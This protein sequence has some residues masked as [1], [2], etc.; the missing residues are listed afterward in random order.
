MAYEFFDLGMSGD[1]IKAILNNAILGNLYQQI[2]DPDQ[3]WLETDVPSVTAVLD[4][5]SLNADNLQAAYEIYLNETTT[6]IIK[7]CIDISKNVHADTTGLY[8]TDTI[9]YGPVDDDATDEIEPQKFIYPTG[10]L[11]VPDVSESTSFTHPK[12]IQLVELS[13]GDKYAIIYDQGDDTNHVIR[14]N[15]L[16]NDPYYDEIIFNINFEILDRNS[17]TDLLNLENGRIY[18]AQDN[19]NIQINGGMDPL[20]ALVSTLE[21]CMI[22]TGNDNEIGDYL[23]VTGRCVVRYEYGGEAI[24]NEYDHVTIK[25]TTTPGEQN[26]YVVTITGV[27]DT[28]KCIKYPNGDDTVINIG[29]NSTNINTELTPEVEYTGTV[30]IGVDSKALGTD[31]ISIGHNSQSSGENSVSIGNYAIN[32]NDNSVAIGP[33]SQTVDERSVAVGYFAQAEA[34][35]SIAIGNQADASHTSSIALGQQAQAQGQNC[36]SIGISSST[37][38]GDM[39]AIAIGGDASSD[40]VYS[41]AIGGGAETNGNDSISIGDMATTYDHFSVSIGHQAGW[42]SE[43][44]D[45]EQ[46]ECSINIG[47]GAYTKNEEAIALGYSQKV[48]GYRSIGIGAGSGDGI[49]GHNSVAIGAEISSDAARIIALGNVSQIASDNAVAIGFHSDVGSSSDGSIAIGRQAAVGDSAPNSVAIGK[50]AISS[51]A[52]NVQIGA[53]TNNTANSIQWKDK[54]LFTY[55]QGTGGA[56]DKY[57]LNPDLVQSQFETIRTTTRIN[58]NTGLAVNVAAARDNCYRVSI[59]GILLIDKTSLIADTDIVLKLRDYTGNKYIAQAT[60]PYADINSKSNPA[61]SF[62]FD[63]NVI[64]DFTYSNGI[65]FISNNVP[66]IQGTDSSNFIPIA[67]MCNYSANGTNYG[68]AKFSNI[69]ILLY[70]GNNQNATILNGSYMDVKMY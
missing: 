34:S 7:K 3:E 26:S 23:D 51:A 56:P 49:N 1:S 37:N 17:N 40:G 64:G 46:T 30:A 18:I 28:L 31:V 54:T 39:G 13:N 45:P 12:L 33:G 47:A 22:I 10:E 68:A 61:I 5:F 32:A 63:S 41:I 16:D 36:I 29:K 48:G 6:A 67:S 44:P 27:Q 24:T 21:Q 50:Q 59:S 57:S 35:D 62:T 9:L 25:Y 14:L 55:E 43:T 70:L 11:Y 53:G 65:Y 69:D 8:Y 66:N 15:V 52:E 4:Y 2:S 19:A 42:L 38:Y 20:Y 60:I 58:S